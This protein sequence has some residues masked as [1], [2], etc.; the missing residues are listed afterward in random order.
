MH[1]C[2]APS[3]CEDS[4]CSI[5]LFEFQVVTCLQCFVKGLALHVPA[6]ALLSGSHVDVV[7]QGF[8][9]NKDWTRKIPAQNQFKAENPNKFQMLGGR[10][11]LISPQNVQFL[12]VNPS[13]GSSIAQKIQIYE[14]GVKL[15][16]EAPF[17]Q[18]RFGKRFAINQQQKKLQGVGQQLQPISPPNVKSKR[19]K[20]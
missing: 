5:A 19:N 7:Q 14:N 17:V 10:K 18:P 2:L 15:Q 8:V 13:L 3:S 1:L 6:K 12:F 4:S 20:H 16:H 9:W 11:A